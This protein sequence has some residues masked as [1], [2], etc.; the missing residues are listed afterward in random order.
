MPE[1][2]EAETIARTLA[3]LIRERVICGVMLRNPGSLDGP[4][5]LEAVIGRRIAGT[6]RRGKLV[7]IRF[8]P[9]AGNAVEG[10]AVHLR[11]TG[12]LFVY[13]PG[14][15][16]GPHTRAVFELS[17]GNRLFFDDARK[18]GCLRVL[19]PRSLASWPFWNT[20]GPEPLEIGPAAFVAQLAGR[21]TAIKAL[22][23]NQTV[24][25]GIGNIYADESL[26]RAG[27]APQSPASGL[28]TDRLGALHAALVEVLKESIEA[29][30]SSIRDYRTARGDAGAF[31]NAFRVYGRG[32]KPCVICGTPLEKGRVAGRTTVWCPHC[33]RG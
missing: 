31:Q 4:E 12:R 9:V 28:S 18:F 15:E 17:D 21:R 3:P 16:P 7:L 8:A 20:L 6:G 23:L 29:C 1:L 2:P 30:G 26:F 14:E 25:A 10:L 27:I 19:S 32:G 22:L 24:I 11:M 13:A 5:P 33:Q